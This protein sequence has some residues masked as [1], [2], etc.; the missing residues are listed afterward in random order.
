V[1]G[2]GRGNGPTSRDAERSL[3]CFS[4]FLNLFKA[5]KQRND[6][7]EQKQCELASVWPF[8]PQPA[9]SSLWRGCLRDSK[10]LSL[11]FHIHF[12]APCLLRFDCPSR[13]PP[14]LP[15]YCS[16]SASGASSSLH[17]C[18]VAALLLGPRCLLLGWGA[19]S[20]NERRNEGAEKKL[21]WKQHSDRWR[22]ACT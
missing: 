11:P 21:M 3:F 7:E 17:R 22:N 6:A 5:S 10:P 13:P 20:K 15:L 4:L 9:H 16:A 19:G 1:S 2:L 18:V 12:M 14:E 8:L